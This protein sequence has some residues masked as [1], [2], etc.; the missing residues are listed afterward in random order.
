[1]TV[2]QCNSIETKSAR[3]VSFAVQVAD[4]AF[5]QPANVNDENLLLMID[6]GYV[7][8]GGDV[9]QNGSIDIGDM[10]PVD[11]DSGKYLS[12][13]LVT[14]INGDGQVDAADMTINDYNASTFTG[15]D[16]PSCKKQK[17]V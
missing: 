1:M 6:G 7:I 12:G 8:Y 16:H 3:P 2:K 17:P 4:V 10:T 13:Y 15:A 14:D 11:N 5:D 9:N